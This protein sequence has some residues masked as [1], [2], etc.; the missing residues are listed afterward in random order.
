MNKT[1]KIALILLITVIAL[2]C[3]AHFT[4][5]DAMMRKLHGG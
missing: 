5:F 3:A 4:H 2:V 1:G